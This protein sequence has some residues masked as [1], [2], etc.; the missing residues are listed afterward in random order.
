MS[1]QWH[2]GAQTEPQRGQLWQSLVTLL[3]PWSARPVEIGL[4]F[5]H[6]GSIMVV[7]VLRTVM[8]F[9]D[10]AYFDHAQQIDRPC[11]DYGGDSDGM[12]MICE[13]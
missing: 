7:M 13:V 10:D 5:M 6:K 4:R 8:M 9:F 11:Y 1:L 12:R 3:D 2:H